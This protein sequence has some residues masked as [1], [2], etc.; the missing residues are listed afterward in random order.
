MVG[1]GC[2]P[3]VLEAAGI[4]RADVVV[5]D[6]GDDE[7]NLVV[8]LIAGRNSEARCIARVNNPKNKL[9]FESINP[10]RPIT[11]ISSTE[12]ILDSINAHVNSNDLSLIA[13]LK[14]RR[15]R[16][17]ETSNSGGRAGRRQTHRGHRH[18]AIGHRR[19][20]RSLGR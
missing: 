16:T 4:K 8:C 18:S 6:T 1:D 20:R 15:A 17:R 19:G 2:D 10:E 13:K 14:K 11:L 5:A 7:D 12:V 9:I 3:M